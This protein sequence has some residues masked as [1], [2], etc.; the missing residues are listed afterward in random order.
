[1]ELEQR[2]FRADPLK[3]KRLRVAAGL[4][5]KE[6]KQIANLDRATVTK[7]LRGDP[8]FLKTLAT[9]GKKVFRIDNPVEL[10]HPDELEAM[11]VQTEVASSG[12]V[13]EWKIEAYLSGWLQTTNGL[14]F[15]LVRLGHRYLKDRMARGKCYELRHLTG[16]ERKRV[17]AYLLRHVEVCE[18][19]G[20]KI[21][22]A[23]NITAAPI[24]GVWWVL[25]RWEDGENLAARLA[26]RAL[27]GYELR[28]V[29]TG[30]ATGLGELHKAD[31]ILRELSP[32]SVLLR[33]RSDKPILTDMELA[34]LAGNA[35]TVSPV[36]WPDDPYRAL[37]VGGDVPVDV[38]ADIYS[39]GRIFIH[40]ATGEL[41]DR[42]AEDL[43]M[44]DIPADVSDLVTRCVSV[45][46]SK[47]PGSVD[48][49]LRVLDRWE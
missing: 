33:E 30:I 38:R 15:Q 49:L 37:E 31:I 4:T 3:L 45:T 5:V 40:A 1:M 11:G 22:V 23:Q 10:L 44:S 8:V 41:C 17:E 16:S 32:K 25:D 36:K 6:F 34:K 14:Q 18:Q 35:Q 46:R 21:N 20:E 13:L 29:M 12:Q 19:I 27:S 28:V 26:T 24:D 47:R 48:D 9:A 2:R 43:S 42:G 7:M 39:W